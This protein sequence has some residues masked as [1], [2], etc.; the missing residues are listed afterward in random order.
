ME[1]GVTVTCDHKATISEV[2]VVC[3][4]VIDNFFARG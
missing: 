2:S 3:T 4:L 1:W